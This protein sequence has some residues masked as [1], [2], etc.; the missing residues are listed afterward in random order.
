MGHRRSS[1]V[2]GPEMWSFVTAHRSAIGMVTHGLALTRIRAE[3]GGDASRL[4][5]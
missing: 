3:A 5:L 2:S 4:K 1:V